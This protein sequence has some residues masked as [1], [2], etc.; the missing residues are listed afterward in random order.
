MMDYGIESDELVTIEMVQKGH[1]L[2]G[3]ILE[4]AGQ[5]F[6]VLGY[7]YWGWVDDSEDEN[8]S[9]DVILYHITTEWHTN[10]PLST[11]LRYAVNLTEENK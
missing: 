9:Y 10:F 6:V 4:V 5:L 7:T 8:N 2:P 11:V 1:W 3:A